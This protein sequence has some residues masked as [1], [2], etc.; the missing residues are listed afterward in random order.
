MLQVEINA[1]ARE[2]INPMTSHIIK[3]WIKISVLAVRV[4]P[5]KPFRV[6]EISDVKDTRK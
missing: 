4:L 3:P 6:L 5:E 2:S 1:I